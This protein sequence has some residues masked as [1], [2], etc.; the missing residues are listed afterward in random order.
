MQ[1]EVNL[2]GSK[3]VR[4]VYKLEAQGR[5]GRLLVAI[6]PRGKLFP[7]KILLSLKSFIEGGVQLRHDLLER[8]IFLKGRTEGYY[9]G[10]V[11]GGIS[12]FLVLASVAGYT[13]N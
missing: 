6:C 11:A 1:G 12:E 8:P 13:E 5:E 4:P 9:T 7:G 3:A 2:P 10:I